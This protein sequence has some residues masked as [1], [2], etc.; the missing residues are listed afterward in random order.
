MRLLRCLKSLPA[1]SCAAAVRAELRSGSSHS[2]RVF[3]FW[4]FL[5]AWQLLK[6]LTSCDTAE[7]SELLLRFTFRY[8]IFFPLKTFDN[9]F[10]PDMFTLAWIP[11]AKSWRFLPASRACTHKH[12]FSWFSSSAPSPRTSLSIVYWILFFLG[13]IYITSAGWWIHTANTA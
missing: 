10:S 8:G 1:V 3:K 11:P 12:L 9:P 13:A 5:L 2:K 6:G 7:I 4:C